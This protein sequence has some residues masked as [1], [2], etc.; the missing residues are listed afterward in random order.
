MGKLFKSK[1]FIILF[2]GF[3]LALG[4]FNCLTTLIEQIL[5]TKGYTDEDSGY[6]GAG[7]IISGLVGSLIGGLLLDKTKRF[8]EISKICFSMSAITSI[9][10]ALV[11]MWNNDNSLVYYLTLFSFCVFGFFGLPLLPICMEMSVECV[12]PIPEATSTGLLFIAGQLVGIVLILIYPNVATKIEPDS[13]VYNSIQTCVTT[14]NPPVNATTP[15]ATTTESSIYLAVLDYSY[16]LY[17]QTVV[18]VISALGFVVFFKC[19]YL[20][21]RSEQEKLAERILKSA[22]FSN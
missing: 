4:I 10:I 22:T 16:P 20:R 18:S 3:G 11:L 13:F 2:F 8:E 17:F 15:F 21:L 12:Y 14:V 19:A 5:C 9:C 7:M 6:F 1:D